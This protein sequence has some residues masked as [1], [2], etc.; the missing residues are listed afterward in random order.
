MYDNYMA[1]LNSTLTASDARSN[2]YQLL[3]EAVSNL[4][5]FTIKIRGKGNA[6][7][8]SED[9]IEGWKETLDIMSDPALMKRLKATEKSKRV[10]TQEQVDKMLKW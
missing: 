1:Q 10:Y 4:R 2:F 5:Q 9:E 6:I 3:D 8:M 7:I